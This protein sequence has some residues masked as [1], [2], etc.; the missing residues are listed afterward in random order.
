MH[1]AHFLSTSLSISN[2]EIIT[3]S[4]SAPNRY[5]VYSIPKRTSGKRTIAHPAKKL[6]LVQRLLSNHLSTILPVH[7]SA[8]AYRKGLGIKDNAQYHMN[9]RYLLKMDFQNFFLSIVPELLFITLK[10]NAIEFSEE[11]EFLMSRLLFWR[12]SKSS[13]GKLVLSIGAP[14]SPLISNFIMFQFDQEMAAKCK[15]KGVRYSRYADDLTFSTNVKGALFDLTSLVKELLEKHLLGYIAINETKT[16]FS[17]KA[18]NRHVTGVTLTND[19]QLSIGRQR[20]RF[21]SSLIHQ[22]SLGKLP[23]EDLSYLQGLIAYA[24]DIEPVFVK[25]MS[26]KYSPQTMDQLIKGVK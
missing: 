5:K 3:F 23:A 13:S 12:P 2:Q 15:S 9:G 18:H 24:N 20:K 21:I 8:F 17:S 10:K 11:D 1:L 26:K 6:K 14:S 22:Y 25:R 19:G 7:E 4:S 16:V